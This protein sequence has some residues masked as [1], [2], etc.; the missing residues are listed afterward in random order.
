MNEILIKALQLLLSLSIL[1]IL[2]ELGHFI[3]A[4]IFKTRV[5][6]FYLF[7][8]V[9]FSIFKKKIN[10]TVYGIGWLPLGGYVK[11]SGMVD[12]SFDTEQLKSEP[13]PW[14][15]RSK[16][17]W[18][19]LIIILGGVTVNLILG[20][21]IYMMI[22]FVWG[23]DTLYSDSL[24]QGL[25]PSPIAKEIG[26]Q[27]SDNIIS[28][29]GKILDNV[30]DINKNLFLRDIKKVT[31]KRKNGSEETLIIPENIGSKMFESGELFPLTPKLDL[32]VGE[33]VNN[34]PAERSGLKK[35][36]K[37]IAV[38]EIEIN[39][40]NSFTTILRERKY[41][42]INLSVI[43]KN[44]LNL[45]ESK[46]ILKVFPNENGTIG[47]YRQNI[48]LGNEKLTFLT[49]IKEGFF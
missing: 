24:P 32:I 5:E 34:S 7:F 33:V 26:F 14:E 16:P 45:S 23:K 41:D 44:S 2:H 31:V 40:F 3:P 25:N 13:K 15:Y 29:D 8:D 27:E 46:E 6:K 42:S 21:F 20:F 38:N 4:K 18:Q 43:R 48:K 30:L 11:I 35:G 22:L 10:D 28:V 12:E 17:A 9:K 19:R 1:V 47:F 36:D 39:D 37:I 49:S